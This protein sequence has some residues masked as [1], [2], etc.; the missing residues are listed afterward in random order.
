MS[1]ILTPMGTAYQNGE[2]DV[3][4]F[5]PADAMKAYRLDEE[6]LMY[7]ARAAGAVYQLP[8]ITLINKKRMDEYMTHKKKIPGCERYVEQ[9][10]VRMGEGSV[11][12]GVGRNRFIEMS[13]AA[14]AVYKIGEGIVLIRLDLF[15]E[16]M[17]R[18]HQKRVKPT[19]PVLLEVEG[20]NGDFV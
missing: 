15:D 5:R 19:D 2:V 4:F 3:K 7:Y 8:R 20:E 14:G 6:L 13:R 18:F 16:Y 17:E 1:E 12:Y 11:I 9:K 10:F